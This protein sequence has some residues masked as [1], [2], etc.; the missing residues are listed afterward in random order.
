VQLLP[1]GVVFTNRRQHGLAASS[2]YGVCGEWAE[3]GPAAAPA[4]FQ[5][6]RLPL[7]IPAS[8][9]EIVVELDENPLTMCTSTVQNY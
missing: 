4:L 6:A 7:V 8:P 9:Q 5:K 1:D 2:C 3:A